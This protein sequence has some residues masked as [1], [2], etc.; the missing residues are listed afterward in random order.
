MPSCILCDSDAAVDRLCGFD[1]C[2]PCRLGADL[3]A[4]L[5]R[6]GL[7][8]EKR[9]WQETRRVND[10]TE[11]VYFLEALVRYPSVV[12]ARAHFGTGPTAEHAARRD[13]D[14]T[15]WQRVVEW[16]APRDI[17]VGDALFDDAVFIAEPEGDQLEDLIADEGVQTAIMELVAAGGVRLGDGWLRIR[18]R[19]S[20]TTPPLY[21]H[22][23][24]LVLLAIHLETYGRI[25]APLGQPDGG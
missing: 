21:E 24:P 11:T 2:A 8:L 15:L 25:H 6:W 3:E 23:V 22:G 20:S 18:R 10:R 9:E 19:S 4:N 12:D 1:L 13:P 5:A 16:F 17:E 7:S 14:A